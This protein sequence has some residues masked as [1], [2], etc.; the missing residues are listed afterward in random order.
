[1][2][3]PRLD[4][5]SDPPATNGGPLPQDELQGLLDRASDVVFRYRVRPTRG[6]EYVSE[7][8]TRIT[9][10]TPAEL[11]ENPDLI[12]RLVHRDDRPILAEILARGGGAT[13]I[14]LRWIGK[15]GRIIWVEQRNSAVRDTKGQIVAIE[16]IARETSD[17]TAGSRPSVRI[18]GDLRIDLDRSRALIDGRLVRLTPAE[19]RLLLLLTD[20]PG[21][22]VTR[23]AI[24]EALWD[25]P[26]RGSTRVTEVH[27]SKLRSKIERDPQTPVRIETVRGRGYRYVVS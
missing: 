1:M 4:R 15:D 20:Q 11:Y 10:F 9:G 7:A 16:A 12:M 21:R 26:S 23:D 25:S 18:I 3:R 13:Q 5:L 24:V 22:I 17:P 19:F 6:F 27:V 2:A 14:V 8:M